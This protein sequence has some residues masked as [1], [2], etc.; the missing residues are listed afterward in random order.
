MGKFS[1]ELFRVGVNPTLIAERDG[2]VTGDGK[3]RT[4]TEEV[5]IKPT[6]VRMLREAVE[7]LNSAMPHTCLIFTVAFCIIEGFVGS[8]HHNLKRQQFPGRFRF[9]N[10]NTRSDPK[11]RV[12]Y[13]HNVKFKR[14]KYTLG[15]NFR[16]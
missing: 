7:K 1:T 3:R 10:T 16:R 14:F 6:D 13:S 12:I 11:F 5:Y 15:S 8:L 4:T 9:R 2:I